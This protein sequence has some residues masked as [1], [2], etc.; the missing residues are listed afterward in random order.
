MDTKAFL[1]KRLSRDW[2]IK[3]VG[4]LSLGAG[5]NYWMYCVRRVVF[6]R[7]LQSL[8]F[9]SGRA[10]DIGPGT[11]FYVTE[12][13]KKGYRVTGV[14]I[15]PFA[16]EQLARAFPQ[17]S[18]VQ[19]DVADGLAGT[20]D[21]ITAMDVLF[22]IVDE[23]KYKAALKNIS[24]A[25][26]PHG[27]FVFSDNFPHTRVE[28]A[29]HISRSDAEITHALHSAGLEIVERRPMF[30]L[31]NTPVKYGDTVWWRFCRGILQRA[32]ALGWLL[33]AVLFPLEY[34]LTRFS[35]HSASTEIVICRKVPQDGL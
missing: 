28:V 35:T 11:G 21:L 29:H 12:L 9:A 13:L 5:F 6:R 27:R 4:Y 2:S 33:G 34:F 26:A 10:C 16:V 19:G 8:P 18:F 1:D 15:S 3:G 30:V 20:Y 23:A 24:A 25:L 32:S 22:H 17:A 7:T 14:D 31:M